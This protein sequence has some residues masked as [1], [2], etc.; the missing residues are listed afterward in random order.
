MSSVNREAVFDSLRDMNYRVFADHLEDLYAVKRVVLPDGNEYTVTISP[1]EDCITV[2]VEDALFVNS[3]VLAWGTSGD[4]LEDVI[5][6][7]MKHFCDTCSPGLRSCR[8]D[9][10]TV[11][12]D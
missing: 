2:Q 10:N 5:K 4:T 9:S 6:R 11:G 1:K 3:P 7:V 12:G 8:D